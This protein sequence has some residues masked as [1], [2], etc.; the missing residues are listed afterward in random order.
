MDRYKVIG[1]NISVKYLLPEDCPPFANDDEGL[2]VWNRNRVKTADNLE[3][4]NYLQWN[5]FSDTGTADTFWV[6]KYKQ[7]SGQNRR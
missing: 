1:S 6:M 2:L 5:I 7:E 3:S 4:Y